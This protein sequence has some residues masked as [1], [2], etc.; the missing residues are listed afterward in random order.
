MGVSIHADWLPLATNQSPGNVCLVLQS[1]MHPVRHA[2]Y[3]METGHCN[4]TS[5]RV[6]Q[7]SVLSSLGGY[8]KTRT[9]IRLTAEVG[10]P[11]VNAYTSLPTEAGVGRNQL[12]HICLLTR[13]LLT[14]GKEHLDRYVCVAWF[15]N[16]RAKGL[17]SHGCPSSTHCPLCRYAH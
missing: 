5:N 6:G 3:S 14:L 7:S 8:R 12:T 1:S 17:T 4:A 15:E 13:L 9:N 11:P 2:S 16:L 10:V